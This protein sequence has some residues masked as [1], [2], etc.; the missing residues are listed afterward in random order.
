MVRRAGLSEM[1]QEGQDKIPGIRA[2]VVG[3]C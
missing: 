3:G 2:K 1:K